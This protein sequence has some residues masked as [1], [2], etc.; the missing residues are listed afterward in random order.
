M[1]NAIGVYEMEPVCELESG[2]VLSRFELDGHRRYVISKSGGFGTQNLL[3]ELA[4]M[5]Q[6]QTANM[7]EK[8][9]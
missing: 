2:V 7:E 9:R 5:L 8:K 1:M 4:A 3:I 6:N